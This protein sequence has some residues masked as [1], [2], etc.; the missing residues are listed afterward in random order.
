M[1]GEVHGQRKKN[2]NFLPVE[3]NGC[4]MNDAWD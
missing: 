1:K 3:E 2:G 4:K